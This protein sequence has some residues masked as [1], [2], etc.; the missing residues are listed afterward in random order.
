ML[1]HLSSILVQGKNARS[2]IWADKNKDV[3]RSISNRSVFSKE[4]MQARLV[5]V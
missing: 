5:L 2:R 3:R 1:N 4:E